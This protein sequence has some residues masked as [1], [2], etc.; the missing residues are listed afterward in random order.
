MPIKVPSNSRFKLSDAIV[1]SDGH[2]TFGLMKK[3]NFLDSEDYI[4]YKITQ[5]FAHRPDRIADS[6]YGSP[7]YFWVVIMY[8]K[9]RNPLLWPKLGEIIRLP[10]PRVVIPEL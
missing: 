6:I 10:P 5:P 7:S 8:N 3:F 9:Q 4:E 2:E 1:T